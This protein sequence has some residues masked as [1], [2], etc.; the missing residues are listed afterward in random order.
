MGNTVHG[1]QKRNEQKNINSCL[2]TIDNAK[3][4]PLSQELAKLTKQLCQFPSVRGEGGEADKEE[5]YLVAGD[6]EQ[7]LK[8][9]IKGSPSTPKPHIKREATQ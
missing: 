6:M 5:G 4:K 1:V 8:Q 3:T 7:W 2:A 9:M